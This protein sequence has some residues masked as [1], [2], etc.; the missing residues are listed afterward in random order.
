MYGKQ[1]EFDRV[2]FQS[3]V[4]ESMIEKFESISEKTGRKISKYSCNFAENDS[5]TSVVSPDK[6]TRKRCFSSHYFTFTGFSDESSYISLRYSR[7]ELYTSFEGFD[8][9]SSAESLL[10]FFEAKHKES[11]LPADL[12]LKNVEVFIGHGGSRLWRDLK[13]HLQ[14]QHGVKVTAYE[15]GA[16]AGFTIQEVLADLS[17][18]ASLALLVHTGEDTD[19][20]G[21]IHARENVVH[22]T[23]LFQGKLGFRRAIVILEEGTTEFSN[24]AGLQQIR[25]QKGNIREIFGEV[26]AVLRREFASY[27]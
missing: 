17:A 18:R 12:V 27:N 5:Y 22:E 19:Q 20:R 26:L 3:D 8:D 24:I 23:G 25:F 14:D 15:T 4:F 1:K 16:R 2:R 21:H 10:H 13:D 9:L 7:N 6:D 11:K